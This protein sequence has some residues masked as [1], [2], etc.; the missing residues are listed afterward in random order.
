[1]IVEKHYQLVKFFMVTPQVERHLR[2][3][4]DFSGCEWNNVTII[5]HGHSSIKRYFFTEQAT[6]SLK[7][8]WAE[9]AKT[10]DHRSW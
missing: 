10:C 7:R 1:M 6:L 5:F 9:L 4:K 3:N 8:K 2:L